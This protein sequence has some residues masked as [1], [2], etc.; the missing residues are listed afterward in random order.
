MAFISGKSNIKKRQQDDRLGR[1]QK[2]PGSDK[3]ATLADKAES[4]IILKAMI[5][6]DELKFV[7]YEILSDPQR[8]VTQEVE[9]RCQSNEKGSQCQ[10]GRSCCHHRLAIFKSL[11]FPIRASSGPI[12][13]MIIQQQLTFITKKHKAAFCYE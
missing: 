10:C 4:V 2:M 7:T 12:D 5:Y 3:M 11:G 6:E 9:L 13:D 1:K 8:S